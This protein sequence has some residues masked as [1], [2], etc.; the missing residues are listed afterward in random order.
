MSITVLVQRN[1]VIFD[2][3]GTPMSPGTMYKVKESDLINGY[4]SEGALSVVEP[5]EESTEVKADVKK[6]QST[7]STRTQES[8][9]ANP[10]ENANG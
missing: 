2:D 9:A 4:I 8:D 7:K 1:H 5:T 10:Q 3:K 6:T